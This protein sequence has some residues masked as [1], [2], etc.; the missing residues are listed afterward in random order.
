SHPG[1]RAAAAAAFASGACS[2]ARPERDH[3]GGQ[4]W[5]RRAA[6][7]PSLHEQPALLQCTATAV[8]TLD[9]VADLMRECGF[10][11]LTREAGVLAAPVPETGAE[12]V[13]GHVGMA[14]LGQQ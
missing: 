4:N 6:F 13:H 8:G 2:R 12:A 1:P 3:I 14:E 5:R 10:G 7:R 9:L 11:D